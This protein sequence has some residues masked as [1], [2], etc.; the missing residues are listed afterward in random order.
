MSVRAH[1][2]LT[3]PALANLKRSPLLVL[4]RILSHLHE[5]SG[6]ARPSIET[7]VQETGLSERTVQRSI[8]TLCEQ[9]VV[10][11]ERGGGRNRASVY[12]FK[13]PVTQG[14][15]FSDAKPRHQDDTLFPQKPRQNE[16]KTPSNGSQNPVTQ[17]DTP[18]EERR[19]G[20]A[21][22]A[23]RGASRRDPLW[24]AV[25]HHF[26][27]RPVAKSE[28]SRVG[29]VVRDLRAK[30][31]EPDDVGRRI[32]RY[33]AA[34]PNITCTPE[35]LLKHWDAFA[36]PAGELDADPVEPPDEVFMDE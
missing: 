36:E 8:E 2:I 19:N 30:G 3:D 6:E 28:K 9:G 1:R 20:G 4:C 31:A 33:R 7:L 18:T 23:S 25:V 22:T 26:R 34:W 32:E 27:L 14:D 15:T 12:R 29:R 35:A 10:T 16:A 24:D 21:R 17:G 13:N 11:V 5:R